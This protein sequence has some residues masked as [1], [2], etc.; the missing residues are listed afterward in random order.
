MFSEPVLLSSQLVAT[1]LL[2]VLLLQLHT[3][4]S[5]LMLLQGPSRSAILRRASIRSEKTKR[6]E[7]G[8]QV[9]VKCTSGLK[10]ASSRCSLPFNQSY[11]QLRSSASYEAPT[12]SSPVSL[13]HVEFKF[14]SG[15]DTQNYHHPPVIFL[16]GLLGQKRNFDTIGRSL[17]NQLRKSRRILAVDLRNHGE[18]ISKACT[19][20]NLA[21]E[22]LNFTILT[23]SLI[24]LKAKTFTTLEMI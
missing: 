17:A 19:V 24:L 18:L 21:L 4:H 12:S 14:G 15:Q 3:T 1:L 7:Y 22:S 20:R 10:I 8:I 11:L 16:H 2:V 13:R 5:Y 9:M 6:R 23:Q